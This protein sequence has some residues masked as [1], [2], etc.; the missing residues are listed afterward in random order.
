MQVFSDLKDQMW[1]IQL[2]YDTIRRIT[3]ETGIDLSSSMPGPLQVHQFQSPVQLIQSSILT[4]LNVLWSICRPQA[5]SKGIKR[6]WWEKQMVYPEDKE[7]TDSD[8]PPPI[9]EAL[10]K[11]NAELENFYRRNGDKQGANFV[12]EM[13]VPWNQPSSNSANNSPASA[14]SIPESSHSGS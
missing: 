9:A 7:L 2:D 1:E 13:A 8:P 10:T 14:G 6:S 5:E 11:L 3:A 12:A 4:R